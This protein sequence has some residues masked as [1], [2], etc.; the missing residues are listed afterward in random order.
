MTRWSGQ[1]IEP[2]DGL[3]YLGKNPGDENVY[4]IT[5]GNFKLKIKLNV[6]KD[7]D[8]LNVNEDRFLE[9][10]RLIYEVCIEKQ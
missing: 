5:G 3:A 4:I 1:I 8:E 6:G 10:R 2:H 7:Q 9:M